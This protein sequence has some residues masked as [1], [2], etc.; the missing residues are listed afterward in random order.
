MAKGRRAE[1]ERYWRGV[2]KKQR[3]SGL[4]VAE[5]CRRN[6]VADVLFYRWRRRLAELDAQQDSRPKAVNQINDMDRKAAARFVPIELPP[7]PVLAGFEVI[8]PDGLR[9]LVPAAFEGEALR[10]LLRALEEV[11][12]C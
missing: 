11:L 3:A 1:R 7:P 10:E 6:D 12:G 5:F 8:R 4:S 2:I 9:V